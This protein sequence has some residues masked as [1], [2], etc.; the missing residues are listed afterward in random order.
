MTLVNIA[1]GWGREHAHKNASASV[2][3]A[4]AEHCA[5]KGDEQ[6]ALKR[7]ADSLAYSLGYYDVRTR[8]VSEWCRKVSAC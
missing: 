2:C 6:G 7:A 1:L 3:L 4:D 8:I 5:A